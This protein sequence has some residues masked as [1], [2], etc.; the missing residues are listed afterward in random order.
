MNKKD[1]LKVALVFA[2]TYVV[3]LFILAGAV[4]LRR[5]M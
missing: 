5:S 1:S 4:Y 3:L 2:I